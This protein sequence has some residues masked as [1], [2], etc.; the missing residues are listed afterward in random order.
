[1]PEY[2]K[3]VI[4]L[5]KG[6]GKDAIEFTW[7]EGLT[8]KAG[9]RMIVL[10]LVNNT[11]LESETMAIFGLKDENDLPAVKVI[12]PSSGPEGTPEAY[13]GN[14]NSNLWSYDNLAQLMEESWLSIK[15]NI[16]TETTPLLGQWQVSTEREFYNTCIQGKTG[17]C[18]K[19]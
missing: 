12:K 14:V 19:Y 9:S 4:F 3:M 16:P 5:P 2:P 6:T 15:T 8:K 7:H 1:M 17:R 18:G 10:S 11:K 13:Q